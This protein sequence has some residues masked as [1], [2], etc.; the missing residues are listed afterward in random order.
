MMILSELSKETV[1]VV[2]SADGGD[3]LFAGYRKY[4]IANDLY[5]RYDFYRVF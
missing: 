3:E 5:Q 4:K 1:S 2:L